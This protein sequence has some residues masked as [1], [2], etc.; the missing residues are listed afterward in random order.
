[1]PTTDEQPPRVDAPLAILLGFVPVS[2][3][4]AALVLR[5]AHAGRLEHL[6]FVVGYR[7]A[8]ALLL[9]GVAALV[10]RAAALPGRRGRVA[11]AALLLV[12]S[13]VLGS[14][15]F[16]DDL[17]SYLWP[18]RVALTVALSLLPAALVV[19][20][21]LAGWLERALAARRAGWRRGLAWLA[22]APFALAGLAA[23]VA[24]HI[25]IP[26][27]NPG[28]HL[29]LLVLAG[30]GVALALVGLEPRARPR[31]AARRVGVALAGAWALWSV[32]ARPSSDASLALSRDES[33][34]LYPFVVGL[35]PGRVDRDFPGAE[36]DDAWLREHA[37][38]PR[39]FRARADAPAVP[40]TRP[41]VDPARALVVVVTIDALR[42]DVFFDPRHHAVMPALQRLRGESTV[43]TRAHAPSSSTAPSIASIFT[44]RYLSQMQWSPVPYKRGQRI[45]YYPVEDRE[46]RVAE[47]LPATVDS[48]TIPSIERLRQQY[49]LIRGF[50][51]EAEV[52]TEEDLM[53]AEVVPPLRD[54][55]L[56][57]PG[58]ALAYVHLMD[59]HSPYDSAGTDGSV[60]ENY[61][62]E[63]A[64]AD[65][66]L[67][68]L[69]AALV[70][71]GQWSRTVLIVAA[72][73]GEA[74][75]EHGQKQHGGSLHE[76]LT[77][78]PMLIRVPGQPAREVDAPGSLIDL[79]PTIL[80]LFQLP[81]PG[82]FLGESLLPLVA[83]EP[84]TQT[85]P[86]ALEST[87]LHRAIVFRDGFKVIWRSREDQFELYDLAR[88]PGE[89]DNLLLREPSAARRVA[90]VRRFF[91]A[92]AFVRAGYVTPH[93][94]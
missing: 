27:G 73:H 22:R 20:R 3:L 64:R 78:V 91:R 7:A 40:P 28:P 24:N 83:G 48:F 39:W 71:S 11:A 66:Q 58:A 82:S 53:A 86:I 31:P 45:R 42:H 92:H 61:V 50:R 21:L 26:Y 17:Y 77:H 63:F 19:A 5:G 81:T 68:A 38:D 33:A 34:A 65:E 62:R 23:A 36:V 90:A 67:G 51:D 49:A 69:V 1:M 46:P 14:L 12:V 79:G 93:Y 56:A 52:D 75:G 16:A 10:M 35:W 70:A 25:V 94:W 84:A 9:A 44:G 60:F 59:G 85:R 18:R 55:L 72:D 2:L 4:D 89:L 37:G 80:D 43:F 87:R 32:V 76:E 47:L 30:V 54:W 74:F 15:A 29:G 8:L 6:V 88:D 41:L 57:R 13:L